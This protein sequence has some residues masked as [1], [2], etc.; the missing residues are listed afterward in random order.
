MKNGKIYFEFLIGSYKYT[1]RTTHV[2]YL[3]KTYIKYYYCLYEYISIYI[4]IFIN[5]HIIR[6]D[7]IN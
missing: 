4:D 6:M 2:F 1:Q 5:K 7:I 3:N